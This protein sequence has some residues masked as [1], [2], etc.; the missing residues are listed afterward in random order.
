MQP[1]SVMPHALDLPKGDRSVDNLTIVSK[2]S[3]KTKQQG[4]VHVCYLVDN[5]ENSNVLSKC[6]IKVGHSLCLDS[7]S[8]VHEQ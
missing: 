4:E 7:L 8:R 6:K 5:R 1:R 2:R 3:E